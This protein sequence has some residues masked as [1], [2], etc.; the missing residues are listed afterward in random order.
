MN[1]ILAT[2]TQESSA[3]LVPIQAVIR[4][5]S[6]SGIEDASLFIDHLHPNDL[7]HK[8]MANSFFE[9]ISSLPKIQNHL[10]PNPIG[11]PLEIST[12]E[13]AYAEISVARLLVGYPFEKS[14]SID[15]E[16]RNFEKDLSL[17]L[18]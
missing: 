15:E 16:L 5:A 10:N 6:E 3:E 8:I 14:I 4:N 1:L 11:P 2:I 18:K 17:L 7:G 13:K 9:A 12:F